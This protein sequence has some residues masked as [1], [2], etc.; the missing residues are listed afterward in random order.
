M[1]KLEED[2]WKLK[3]RVNRLNDGGSNTRFFHTMTLNRRRKNK[4]VA[5]QNENGA[6]VYDLSSLILI[7]SKYFKSLFKTSMKSAALNYSWSF[8]KTNGSNSLIHSD[9]CNIP[10]SEEIKRT[11]FSFQPYI[12]PKP[13]SL[14]PFFYQK[15]W[16]IVRDSIASLCVQ[17]FND[18]KIFEY[19]NQTLVY[20][21]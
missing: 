16:W 7:T 8:T 10:T 3:S 17:A 4:I 2:F 6:W 9:L 18:R 13:N 1:L 15:Y 12:A 19:I 20:L 21:K 14:H 5:L 11:L